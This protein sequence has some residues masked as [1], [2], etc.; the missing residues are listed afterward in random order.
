VDGLE[1]LTDCHYFSLGNFSSGT[2]KI[3]ERGTLGTLEM[4]PF[5]SSIKII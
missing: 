4:K 2:I 3:R 5:F 1:E